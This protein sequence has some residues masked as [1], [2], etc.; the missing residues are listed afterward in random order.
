MNQMLNLDL[1]LMVIFDAIM[2]ERSITGAANRLAMTQ[3]AVSNAV[4][5]MRH[6]WND[7]LFIKS[8]RGIQPTPYAT[9]LWQQVRTPLGQIRNSVSPETFQ[10]QQAKRVFRIG[11]TD[12][13]VEL[14]W[15]ALRQL[16]EQQA[17]G[18]ALHAVPY[19]INTQKLLDDAE[20]DLVVGVEKTLTGSEQRIRASAL[21]TLFSVCVMQANHPLA[22]RPLSIEDYIKADHLLVSLSGQPEGYIDQLLAERQLSRRIAM[23]VN[24]FSVAT[25]LLKTSNLLAVLPITALG[26]DAK[27][28]E[29]HITRVPLDMPPI[30]LKLFWHTR[31]DRDQGLR[32]LRGQMTQVAQQ[33]WQQILNCI[34]TTERFANWFPLPNVY[35]ELEL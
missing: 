31:D 27:S 15:P 17:P 35:P 13:M 6:A 21:I 26:E 25:H 14:I 34:S 16:L 18:I 33:Q 12:V 20:V 22:Q 24:H 32:W 30:P 3:P 28:G 7:P 5:R 1:N 19:A 9:T 10:P 2:T 4:A 29:L 11:I 8:G 23:T